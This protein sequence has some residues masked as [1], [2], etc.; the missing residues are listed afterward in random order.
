M[1]ERADPDVASL[2]RATLA[3]GCCGVG[4]NVAVFGM[5]VVNIGQSTLP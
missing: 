3:I 2:I 1:L 4:M 5:N